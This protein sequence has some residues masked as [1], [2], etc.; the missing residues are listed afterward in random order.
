MFILITVG[1]VVVG[2]LAFA[3]L[4]D[5][6]S[7]KPTPLDPKDAARMG[8]EQTEAIAAARAATMVR[9]NGTGPY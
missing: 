4:I 9:G 2:S 7:G 1:V 5:F 6:R 8:D 3:A